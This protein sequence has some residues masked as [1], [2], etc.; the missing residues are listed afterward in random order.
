M[1]L[2]GAPTRMARS[3]AARTSMVNVLACFRWVCS[4]LEAAP[5]VEGDAHVSPGRIDLHVAV[6]AVRKRT[7]AEQVLQGT[8]QARVGERH[9]QANLGGVVG[10]DHE[11]GR[12]SCRERV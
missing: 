3:V 9:G 4:R 10:C 11:I 12:A 5:A 8:A 6:E 2:V 7:R 1:S